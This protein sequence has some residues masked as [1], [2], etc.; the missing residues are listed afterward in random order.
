M[1][2][3]QLFVLERETAKNS[4]IAETQLV[5]CLVFPN[6]NQWLATIVPWITNLMQLTY[7]MSGRQILYKLPGRMSVYI[8]CRPS[9]KTWVVGCI[10]FKPQNLKI[11][12]WQTKGWLCKNQTFSYDDRL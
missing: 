9:N 2:E 7:F 12:V 5:Y 1:N 8:I 4:G 11:K 10:Q 6:I 3:L